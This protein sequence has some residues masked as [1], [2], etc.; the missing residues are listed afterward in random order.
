MPAQELVDKAVADLQSLS[1][2]LKAIGN[3]EERA[4]RAKAD[5]D[6]VSK[7]LSSAKAEMKE[8]DAGLTVAQKDA[9]RRFDLDMFTKQGEL[10]ELVARIDALKAQAAGLTTEVDTKGQ[11]L[12]SIIA[13]M[14]DARRKLSA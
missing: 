7:A 9:Q 5:L 3:L 13:S 12:S 1:A 4:V 8:V 2:E 6:S 10:K 11:Q 14:N